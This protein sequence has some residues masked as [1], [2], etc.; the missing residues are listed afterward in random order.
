VQRVAVNWLARRLSTHRPDAM[1]SAPK[2]PALDADFS[3]LG[4]YPAAR[5]HISTTH[6]L[7]EQRLAFRC[8][9]FSGQL[10]ARHAITITVEVVWVARVLLQDSLC[11]FVG[12]EAGAV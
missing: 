6:G 5:P 10:L 1:K 8:L 9:R 7:I 4:T 3:R 12:F 11:L 2:Q